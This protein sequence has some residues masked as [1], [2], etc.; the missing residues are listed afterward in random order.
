M[1]KIMLRNFDYYVITLNLLSLG[2]ILGFLLEWNIIGN[3]FFLIYNYLYSKL[4]FN[5]HYFFKI[6]ITLCIIF[7]I[8]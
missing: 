4:L 7:I 6:G 1:F 3:N 2:V 5:I 8:M